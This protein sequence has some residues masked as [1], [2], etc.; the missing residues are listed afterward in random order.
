MTVASGP[1]AMTAEIS[2]HS[3][4]FGRSV[5]RL[6]TVE[7]RP[8]GLPYGKI[9]RLHDAALA[10]SGYASQTMAAADLLRRSVRPGDPVFIVTGAG[11]QPFIPEGENDGPVG[12][13]T[14]ARSLLLGLGAVPVYLVEAHHLRPVVTASA[15]AGVPIRPGKVSIG[16]ARGAFAETAP[17][18][19]GEV[20]GWAREMYERYNP[21]AVVFIERLGPN[22]KGVIHGST[23]I[24]DRDPEVDL[25]PILSEAMERG[26]ASIGIGDAG[27]EIGFGRIFDDVRTIQEHGADC[28]E[29]LCVWRRDGHE[30]RDRCP[31]RRRGLELGGLRNRRMPGSPAR[32][33]GSR[34]DAGDRTARRRRVPWL[35]AASRPS[36]AHR[37]T[38][39]MASRTRPPCRSFRS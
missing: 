30:H 6:V 15:A 13:A 28:S 31:R 39:S 10:E 2:A 29:T 33:G 24:P 12:A 23:G 25:T 26:V 32:Q 22:R 35:E 34:A 38:A 4:S 7:M 21:A 37:A 27:N 36:S 18:T 20:S 8:P 11:T 14:I 5:D 19:E 9:D 17:L 16:D 1:A 3:W